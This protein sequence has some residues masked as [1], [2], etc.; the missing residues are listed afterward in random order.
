MNTFIVLLRAV[1]LGA[2]AKVP[3][4]ELCAALEAQ[5]FK[6]V[7][8]YIASG[9]IV[10]ESELSAEDITTKIDQILNEQFNITGKRTVVRDQGAFERIVKRNPFPE[11]TQSRPNQLHLHFMANQPQENAELSLT[12]YKGQERLRLDGDHLYIDYIHGA[13]ESKLTT[14]F[15]EAALGTVGTSR[16]W[17][18]VQKL[19]E[20]CRG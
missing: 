6:N 18:T 15:L 11:A 20:L 17:N 8:S 13:G 12:T 9:N 2:I 7:K 14:R 5:D 1:N 19:L 4:Q 3:M 10:L 16:N